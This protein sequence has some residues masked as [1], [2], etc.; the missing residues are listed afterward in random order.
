ME[1]SEYLKANPS[2]CLVNPDFKIEY[3]TGIE[4]KEMTLH[5]TKGRW[6]VAAW[7]GQL[8]HYFGESFDEALKIF[9][10]GEKR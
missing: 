5:W 6:R 4:E 3:T 9:E 2:Y 8:C 7:D 10:A 1:L